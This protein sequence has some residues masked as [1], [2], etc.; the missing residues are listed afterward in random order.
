MKLNA[1]IWKKNA[2]LATVILFVCVAVYLN[3][4]YGRDSSADVASPDGELLGGT[5]LETEAGTDSL[6]VIGQEGELSANEVIDTANPETNPSDYFA[7]ARLNR[8]QA[9][10]S[11]L[12]ILRKSSEN[13]EASQEIRDG[14]ILDL[15]TIADNAIRE[16]QIESLVIAK[17]FTD[18]V[19][20]I[21]DV[22]VDVV[23]S[24][25]EGGLVAE[26][27]TQIKDIV[28]AE[29]ATSVGNITIL[30]VG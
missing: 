8:Q 19:A 24:S 7:V 6:S 14:A 15:G 25:P 10:D 23:V 27:V 30:E 1:N 22:G 18:C 3:W 28:V 12:S 2:I 20:F 26:Q 4:S 13:T 17:G 21:S 11:S 29:T 9:R 16:A 5:V